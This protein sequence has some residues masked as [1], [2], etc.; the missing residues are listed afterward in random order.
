VADV[1]RANLLAWGSACASRNDFN[2]ASGV[3]V[4]IREL[5][6]FVIA[7]TGNPHQIEYAAARPGDIERFAVDNTKLRRLGL[8]FDSDW[9]ATVRDVIAWMKESPVAHDAALSSHG[10]AAQVALGVREAITGEARPD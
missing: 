7:E 2:C 9:R 6:E 5:A 3:S 8:D 10:S 1:V 4:T